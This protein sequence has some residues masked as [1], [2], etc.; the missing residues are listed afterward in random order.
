[1]ELAKVLTAKRWRTRLERDRQGVGIYQQININD[2]QSNIND[3]KQT[4]LTV[5]CS[6]RVYN[7]YYG[8]LTFDYKDKDWR[9]SSSSRAPRSR[10]G[11]PRWAPCGVP[12]HDL[13]P[14]H[15]LIGPMQARCRA[16]RRTTPSRC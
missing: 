11:L 2:Q 15:R 10:S 1:M 8:M 12:R 7:H 16:R 14:Q 9:P 4:V 3:R 5:E 13:R 6:E